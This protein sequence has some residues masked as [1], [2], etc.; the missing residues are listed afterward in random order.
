MSVSAVLAAALPIPITSFKLIP[1]YHAQTSLLATYTSLFCFL[2]LGFIFYSRHAL[3]RL[4]F[5]HFLRKPRPATIS[6][7]AIRVS[8]AFEKLL[9]LSV[10]LLPAL[11]I[12]ASLWCMVR[13]HVALSASVSNGVRFPAGSSIQHEDGASI[14]ASAAS[15]VDTHQTND[16][17]GSISAVTEDVM[18]K[19][20]LWTIDFEGTLML[21]YLGIF[22]FAECAFII[23]ALKEYLQDL[24]KLS[25][26]ELITGRELENAEPSAVARKTKSAR[27]ID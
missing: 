14:P 18:K 4:M 26:M 11:L 19:S 2:L 3:A 9:R 22:V 13:Y 1:T 8:I 6:T 10:S 12:A 21:L 7:F 17:F 23:M 27:L 20:P 24:V 5:P 25:E 16:P 15:A